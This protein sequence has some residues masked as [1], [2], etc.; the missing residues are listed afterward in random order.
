MTEMVKEASFLQQTQTNLLSDVLMNRDDVAARFSGSSANFIDGITR[1]KASLA[2]A[3]KA[4][5]AAHA[6]FEAQCARDAE[7]LRFHRL[8]CMSTTA[9]GQ[10]FAQSSAFANV[11]A[12]SVTSMPVPPSAPEMPL[13]AVTQPGANPEPEAKA[14]PMGRPSRPAYPQDPFPNATAVQVPAEAQSVLGN[15]IEVVQ[16]IDPETR[17]AGKAYKMHCDIEMYD[18]DRKKLTCCSSSSKL[19]SERAAANKHLTQ[20]KSDIKN[21]M[22]VVSKTKVLKDMR[23]HK[24]EGGLSVMVEEEDKVAYCFARMGVATIDV[25]GCM[26]AIRVAGGPGYCN[27]ANQKK[28]FYPKDFDCKCTPNRRTIP[29]QMRK[30]CRRVRVCVRP[31]E[32]VGVHGPCLLEPQV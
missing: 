5:S 12:P 2:D 25:H 24:L 9:Q 31:R 4:A 29:G 8:D 7:I 11:P 23:S 22:T 21:R 15:G 19:F 3:S 26:R 16:V 27:A 18:A 30:R 10:A 17:I 13:P 14:A 1:M 28:C 6:A 20:H 32:R